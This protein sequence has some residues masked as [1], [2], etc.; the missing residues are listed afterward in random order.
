MGTLKKH[1]G[2]KVAQSSNGY[3]MTQRKYIL[4][5]L[6]ETKLLQGKV[7]STLTKVNPNI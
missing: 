5:L 7:N 6:N 3:L 2:I 4:H 1:F